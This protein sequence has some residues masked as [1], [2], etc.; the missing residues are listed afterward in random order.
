MAVLG[1]PPVDCHCD[2]DRA[3][4]AYYTEKRK[5]LANGT[6]QLSGSQV[7]HFSGPGYYGSWPKSVDSTA[8]RMIEL[9][10]QSTTYKVE[11]G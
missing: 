6:G 11:G 2:P 8:F 10:L 9:H 1:S 4:Q 7:R 5:V 3:S